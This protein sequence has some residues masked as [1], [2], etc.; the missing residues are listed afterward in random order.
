MKNQEQFNVAVLLGDRSNSFWIEMEEQYNQYASEY[1]MNLTMFRGDPEK[2]PAAQLHAF[3]KL[4][5]ADYH[6]IIINPLNQHNLI[7]GIQQAYNKKIPVFDVGKKTDQAQVKGLEAF[8]FPVQTID[9]YQQGQL[10]AQHILDSVKPHG[11]RKVVII[12]GRLN[13]AQS[14][15]RSAGAMD[16]FDQEPSIDVIEAEPADFDHDKAFNIARQILENDK[17]ISGFFCANDHMALGV[18]AAA[19]ALDKN[20]QLIIVGVDGITEAKQAVHHNK[21]SATVAFSTESVAHVILNSVKSVLDG[22]P[23]PNDQWV[24]S[25]LISKI[26]V[27]PV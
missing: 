26:D 21:I 22:N 7:E 23:Q 13:S 19:E 25:E 9:F 20:H 6:G 12:K 24:K 14:I 15:G 4:I 18:S 27:W 17:T 11:A 2:D 3:K 16:T 5:Q 1:G 8:Y 10:G